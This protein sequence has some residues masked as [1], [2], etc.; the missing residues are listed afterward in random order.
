MGKRLTVKKMLKQR[1]NDSVNYVNS[2]STY[3]DLFRIY[4]YGDEI[5]RNEQVRE[6]MMNDIAELNYLLKCLGDYHEYNI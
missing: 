1:L 2:C 4:G 6:N 3:D 5:N